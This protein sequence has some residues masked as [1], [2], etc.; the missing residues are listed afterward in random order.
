MQL[1]DGINCIYGPPA[2]GKTNICLFIAAQAKGKVIFIDTENTFSAERI[3]EFNPEANLDNICLISADSFEKQEKIIK[4][5]EL[6]RKADIIIIDSLTKYY[7]TAL[8]ESEN[9]DLVGQL[10]L[11]R[12]LYKEKGCKILI[13]SQVYTTDKDEIKPLGGKPIRDFSKQLVKL[14]VGNKRI[15]EIIKPEPKKSDFCIESAS[16]AFS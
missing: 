8:K 2:S 14:H 16:V 10:R 1:V 6:L 9:H 7:R 4:E 15:L 12:R 11:L 5:L 13:T 3:R